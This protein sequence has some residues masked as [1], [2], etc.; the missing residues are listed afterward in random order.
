MPRSRRNNARLV[1]CVTTLLL[2]G[3]AAAADPLSDRQRLAGDYFVGASVFLFER[4]VL[5]AFAP[6]EI[7]GAD[8]AEATLDAGA[9]VLAREKAE[10]ESGSVALQAILAWLNAWLSI[11]KK[12]PGSAAP[13]GFDAA[14]RHALACLAY[15]ADPEVSAPLAD[16]IGL[17]SQERGACVARY[18]EARKQWSGWLD[19]YRKS[20]GAPAPIRAAP[21][22]APAEDEPMLRLAF[23]PTFDEA[24]QAIA[25]AVRENGLFQLLT[26]DFNATLAMP[27]AVTALLTQC[28]EPRAFYNPDRGEAVLC[29]EMLGAL[30]QAAP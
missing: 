2:S 1:G 23:A 10:D 9:I 15:G 6:P 18:L 30:A 20:P 12:T 7:T 5:A 8:S 24:D 21:E 26:D 28:G 11:E 17:G 3:A 16:H 19:S 4:T 22:G 29:Y 14:R 13:P 27:R 25:D